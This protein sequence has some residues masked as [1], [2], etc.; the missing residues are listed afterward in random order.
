MGEVLSLEWNLERI[1]RAG[2]IGILRGD[3]P[4]ALIE[5]GLKLAEVGVR[6]LEVTLDS[7]DAARVFATLKEQLG[8]EV[9]LGVGTVMHPPTALPSV[10]EWGAEF[11]LSPVNP[12]GFIQLAHELDILA[13][14]GVATPNELWEAHTAGAMIVKLYPAATNWSPEMLANLPRPLRQV[15]TLPTGGV[16]PEDVISWLDAGAFACGLG[17]RLTIEEA[18][19]LSSEILAR[20]GVMR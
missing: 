17:G 20:R 4:D 16:K 13:V 6:V 10:V 9:M 19:F 15:H 2:F 14:P 12:D 18:G 1:A 11:A 8:D 5:R 7:N 3:D